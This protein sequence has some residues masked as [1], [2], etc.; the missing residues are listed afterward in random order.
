MN[1]YAKLIE[2][3]MISFKESMVLNYKKIGLNEVEA[4]VI[5]LLYENKKHK[6]GAISIKTILPYVTMAESELSKLVVSLVERGYI[7]LSIID[8]NESFQLTPTMQKLGAVIDVEHRTSDDVKEQSA[9]VIHYLEVNYQRPLAASE[10]LIIQNWFNENKTVEE[11]MKVINES[12]ALKKYNLKYAD[13]I[14]ANRSN[15][16]SKEVEVD[17]EMQELM[18]KINVRH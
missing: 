10:L 2:S 8:G 11:M 4:M 9:K 16:T 15:N 7:E 14:M 18:S 1:N 6:S 17:P 13:A 5:I 12:L 3:H